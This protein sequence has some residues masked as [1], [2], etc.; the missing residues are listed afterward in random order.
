MVSHPIIHVGKIP[1]FQ[2][3]FMRDCKAVLRFLVTFFYDAS[4]NL[5]YPAVL[6]IVIVNRSCS[7]F[8]PANQNDFKRLFS[9]NAVS[10]VVSIKP[11]CIFFKF[12]ICDVYS[13][14]NACLFRRLCIIKRFNKFFNRSDWQHSYFVFHRKQIVLTLLAIRRCDLNITII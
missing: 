2:I 13:F 10:R 1:F 12:R 5:K 6:P 4:R 14:Q 11:S 7:F 9:C 3:F 8:L